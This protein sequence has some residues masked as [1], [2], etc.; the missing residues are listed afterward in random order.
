M[1]LSIFASSCIFRR[2]YGTIYRGSN[3]RVSFTL[4][5]GQIHSIALYNGAFDYPLQHTF[6]L[7]GGCA[8]KKWISYE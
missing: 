5:P 1:F 6:F 3:S 2:Y 7:E 8:R 4:R